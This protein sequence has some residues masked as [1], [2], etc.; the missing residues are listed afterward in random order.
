[1]NEQ[2]RQ[3]SPDPAV[4]EVGVAENEVVLGKCWG[5][6][7]RKQASAYTSEYQERI[8]FQEISS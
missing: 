4:R 1:M 7:P 6:L 3:Q 2:G 5:L 8:G